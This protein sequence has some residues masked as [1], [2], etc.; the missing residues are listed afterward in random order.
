MKAC[1]VTTLRK[2]PIAVIGDNASDV[3]VRLYRYLKGLDFDE[4][5]VNMEP[6]EV[7]IQCIDDTSEKS[8]MVLL[9]GPDWHQANLSFSKVW[10]CDA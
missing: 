10:L 6:L 5:N 8:K 9:I 3:R 4:T 2:I 7:L 1:R